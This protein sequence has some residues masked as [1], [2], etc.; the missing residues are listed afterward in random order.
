MSGNV[1][2]ILAI[3]ETRLS[4]EISSDSVRIPK[5]EFIRKDKQRFSQLQ[6]TWIARQ[7]LF[8]NNWNC[9]CQTWQWRQRSDGNRWLQLQFPGCKTQQE[10]WKTKI[11]H[12]GLPDGPT[13]LAESL[14]TL[15]DLILSSKLKRIVSS[16]VLH[17]S[18]S[19]H[20]LIYTVRKISVPTQNN[21]RYQSFGSFKK[22]NSDSAINDRKNQSSNTL[23][24]INDPNEMW[25]A[26]K[27][28]FML[29]LKR[30]KKNPLLGSNQRWK[31]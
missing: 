20:S 27:E 4:N 12:Q 26:R 7:S 2:D 28:M 3:N 17:V 6:V 21:H 15:I 13:R 22:F 8:S 14:Q 18:I 5:H 29:M 19:D 11:Y 10:H 9:Q 24:M 25:K 16:W 23:L 1:I 30:M 31:T